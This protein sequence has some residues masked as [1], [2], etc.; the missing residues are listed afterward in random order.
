MS[1][2]TI[3]RQIT[4]LI[5]TTFIWANSFCQT[6]D[7]SIQDT[8]SLQKL[9]VSRQ[10]FWDHLPEPIGLV[11]D[12]ERIFSDEQERS[13]KNTISNFKAE[14]GIQIVILSLDSAC[15]SKDKFDAL[16][17]HIFNTWGIGEKGK[18]NGVLI[19]ISRG[20]RIMRITNGYGIERIL[21]NEETKTIIDTY[22]IPDFKKGEYYK[23]T[24]TGLRELMKLLNLKN[25]EVFKTLNPKKFN[26]KIA[27]R[28]DIKTPK[29]LAGVYHNYINNEGKPKL[30]IE[31]EKLG[32]NSYKITLIHE[33]LNDDSLSA[34]KTVMKAELNGQTW[35]VTEIKENW[36]CQDGRGHTSWGTGLCN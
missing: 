10:S 32:K 9:S 34:E 11:N 22:F 24:L 33:R 2:K 3:I 26:E 29:E 28:T 30:A 4:T 5:L 15:T 6:K 17:L 36:K 14:T 25:K 1:M 31:T 27:K 20:H 12:F 16:A 35:T 21:S 18:D 23:G 13:L 7:I 19:T 8:S